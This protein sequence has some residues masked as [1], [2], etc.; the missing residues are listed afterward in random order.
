MVGPLMWCRL[1]L[2]SG[3][4]VAIRRRAACETAVGRD[5]LAIGRMRRPNTDTASVCDE[6]RYPVS[7]KRLLSRF[8]FAHHATQILTLENGIAWCPT[9]IANCEFRDHAI[10]FLRPRKAIPYTPEWLL[11]CHRLVHRLG[12]KI[13][14][15]GRLSLRQYYNHIN[16]SSI[17]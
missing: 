11:M 15:G 6:N 9:K 14:V 5:T 7:I 10:A 13:D 8:R 2:C 16:T 3:G 17:A 1:P 12:Y 4:P